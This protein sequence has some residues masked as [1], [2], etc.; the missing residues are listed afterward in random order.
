MVF[1][2]A[3]GLSTRDIQAHIASS[4][5]SRSPRTGIGSHGCSARGGQR[6]A[7]TA[8]GIDLCDRVFR[9]PAGQDPRRG[10]GPQHG[11]VARHRRAL[12]GPKR[13]S[14]ALGRAGGRGQVLAPRHDRTHK[15]GRPKH[16]DRRGR[17]SEGFSRSHRERVACSE[18]KARS[19]ASVAGRA[20]RGIKETARGEAGV[21]VTEGEGSGR[22]YGA[23]C[24]MYLLAAAITSAMRPALSA[25]IGLAPSVASSLMRKFRPPQGLVVWSAASVS[26]SAWG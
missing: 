9:C 2:Y 10:C 17:W 23:P 7:V 6:V 24:S 12:L 8:A 26:A 15:P 19:L 25:A 18:T 20:V 16:P 5:A 13:D 1:L 14:E 11:C 21:R 22:G 3:R 4:T